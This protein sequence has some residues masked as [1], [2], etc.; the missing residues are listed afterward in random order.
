M[1]FPHT[2]FDLLFIRS[3]AI[4]PEEPT[5]LFVT[6]CPCDE[7]VPLI[8]GAGVTHIYTT[9]LDRDKDKVDISY[10][11]FSSLKNI[12]KF[13]VSIQMGAKRSSKNQTLLGESD[14]FVSLIK[15]Q[16]SPAA[17]SLSSPHHTSKSTSPQFILL[18]SP[19]CG[20]VGVSA[21][22]LVPDGCIRK[23]GSLSDEESP[24]S[25]RVCSGTG[26]SSRT[27]NS[28]S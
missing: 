11:M 18:N 27:Y 22:S 15:W 4:R 8:K 5:M 2:V 7:C 12:N 16:R 3:R 10:L 1:S 17:S 25:K 24:A 9:D 28:V 21:A 6:K 26:C 23:L 20:L 19:S 14:M 13:I